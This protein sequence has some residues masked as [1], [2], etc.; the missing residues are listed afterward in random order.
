MSQRLPASSNHSHVLVCIGS[1]K[2]ALF[3][4]RMKFADKKSECDK[5]AFYE[6]TSEKSYDDNSTSFVSF[7]SQKLRKTIFPYP[8]TITFAIGI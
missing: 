5:R 8:R 6:L 1:L 7:I 2:E 3:Q 4:S